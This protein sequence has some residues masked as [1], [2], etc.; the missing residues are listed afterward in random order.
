MLWILRRLVHT[1]AAQGRAVGHLCRALRR[2]RLLVLAVPSLLLRHGWL[3]PAVEASQVAS[4]LE[5]VRLEVERT[6]AFLIIEEKGWESEAGFGVWWARYGLGGIWHGEASRSR[7]NRKTESC[8]MYGSD[9][10]HLIFS[11]VPLASPVLFLFVVGDRQVT[12][13]LASEFCRRGRGV[14]SQSNTPSR[15]TLHSATV[16]NRSWCTRL[17]L[18][19]RDNDEPGATSAIGGG[20]AVVHE[21]ALSRCPQCFTTEDQSFANEMHIWRTETI[22]TGRWAA[23][24][25]SMGAEDEDSCGDCV[26]WIADLLNGLSA[27]DNLK[28]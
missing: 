18:A 4:N 13:L 17:Q 1:R 20:S 11:S 21:K 14:I 28:K 7:G 15:P 8:I 22:S 10:Q 19:D 16:Y 24:D 6:S 25:R 5:N 27:L 12:L 3:K 26:H 9:F 2:C 23:K